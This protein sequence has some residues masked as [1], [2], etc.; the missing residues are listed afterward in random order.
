MQSIQ[1]PQQQGGFTVFV[2][3]IPS[4][5][6]EDG[7]SQ[8][9]NKF[10]TLYDITIIR[11][12][13]TNV[14][15]GC[16]FITFGTKEEADLAIN[17][18]NN[19]NQYIETVGF[20][21]DIRLEIGFRMTKPLQVKYSDNEIEKME[22]KL[23]IGMLGASEE[24][25]VRAIFRPYGFIEELTIVK[26]KD[27]KPKGYGFIKFSTRDESETALR[28]VD[29]KQTLFGS[30]QPIIVKFADTER[31]KRKKMLMGG[32]GTPSGNNQSVPMNP[33]NQF[34]QQ[35][36]PGYPNPFFYNQNS[37]ISQQPMNGGYA[38]RTSNYAG[39]NPYGMQMGGGN[40]NAF[41]SNY[42]QQGEPSNDL[43]IY[44]IPF[45]YG[46]EELKSLFQPYGNVVSAKVFIDKE[47]QQS[48]CF[49][50]VSFDNPQSA[51]QAIQQMNGQPCD[52]KRLKVDFKKSKN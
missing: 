26:E 3:H 39:A 25:Q 38:P 36:A 52:G 46:D 13:R 7:V 6:N 4:S 11:D 23:F 50:F 40:N 34:Y 45:N 18:V 22:R 31:Q 16:A 2:G 20:R 42:N 17:T 8:I 43:F 51:M 14:S 27:G 30:N 5:M 12:K 10:G 21:L 9:F 19:S 37:Q 35:S 28:E 24:E 44:Y 32:N 33:Y 48:K 49:G 29:G 1:Q 47:T 15:K 41:N